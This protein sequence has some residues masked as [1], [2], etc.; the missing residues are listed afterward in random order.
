[1]TNLVKLR[2]DGDYQFISRDMT[3][4]LDVWRVAESWCS[5]GRVVW[6]A[7]REWRRPGRWRRLL[8]SIDIPRRHPQ[9]TERP[10][11]PVLA[12]S[13]LDAPDGRREAGEAKEQ[14]IDILKHVSLEIWNGS[15]I[16][17]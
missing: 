10:R 15:C 12:P 1:M 16:A 13:A 2:S 3:P 17:R 6:W 4:R 9:T 5:G 8:A 11:H 14:G 7:R